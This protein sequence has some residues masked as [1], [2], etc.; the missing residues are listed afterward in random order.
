MKDLEKWLKNPAVAITTLIGLITAI[1]G[2]VAVFRSEPRLAMTITACVVA[3]AVLTTLAYVS[4][5][6]E[7]DLLGESH[8][9]FSRGTRI[10]AGVAG[11][12][13]IAAMV[14]FLVV[15]RSA[16]ATPRRT[17]VIAEF[18]SIP[19]TDSIQIRHR[20]YDE[21]LQRLKARRID[22]IA[23]AMDGQ[24]VHDET[25][26]LALAQRRHAT[27]VIWGWSDAEEA[28]I[29][30]FVRE[31][32]THTT[33]PDPEHVPWSLLPVSGSIGTR[34]TA[35]MQHAGFIA[36]FVIG[37][38]LYLD[39]RWSEGFA[40]LDEAAKLLPPSATLQN[41]ALLHFFRG[42][43]LHFAKPVTNLETLD[44]KY[45]ARVVCEYAEALR[46]DPKFA[47][48]WN[49]LGILQTRWTEVE[50]DNEEAL[51]NNEVDTSEAEACLDRAG[52]GLAMDPLKEAARLQPDNAA[53]EYNRLAGEW[54]FSTSMSDAVREQ[55]VDNL[56][57]LLMRDRSLFGA[58][59]I[60]G[61]IAFDDGDYTTA[62]RELGIVAREHPEVAGIHVNLAQAE[63]HL[64]H[65]AN[66]EREVAIE[67]QRNPRDPLALLARASLRF[68]ANDYAAAASSAE[69][70]LAVK[71]DPTWHE[72]A[73]YLLA[74][75]SAQTGDFARSIKFL[76]EIADAYTQYEPRPL[77]PH[78]L[79]G[80]IHEAAGETAAAALELQSECGAEDRA[81]NREALKMPRQKPAERAWRM[82]AAEC[83]QD[84]PRGS[85]LQDF[86]GRCL[87]RDPRAALKSVFFAIADSTNVGRYHREVPLHG[88]ACPLVFVPEGSA[89]R[90]A[91]AILVNQRG[92]DRD[93]IA[94]QP[95]PAS[96]A[97]TLR[98]SEVEPETSFIDLLQ[99]QYEYAGG[100]TETHTATLPE[101]ARS[102]QRYAILTMGQHLELTFPPPH[103][104]PLRTSI[105]AKGYYLP[106]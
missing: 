29:R 64:G 39:N 51:L 90:F 20:L 16:G 67:L 38:L 68:I 24:V 84:M 43:A 41:E 65:L 46:L 36:M 1:A 80:L 77:L 86:R 14:S 2:F 42:R 85:T 88:M 23:V 13:L 93:V 56:H 73:R 104:T 27:A 31:P 69:A 40:A 76:R 37:Q 81:E 7:T 103:A 83:T 79:L 6:R 60:L 5:A 78:L 89:W 34:G 32:A 10:S 48:A 87:P 58:R 91:T 100:R 35:V 74:G 33:L 21:L 75:A 70:A 25:E 97:G 18:D 57:H 3:A 11:A 72:A 61:I 49:N 106:H 101:L 19:N 4:L 62:R 98:I 94:R 66:A 54:V 52:I 55:F 26:A 22:G 47:A 45:Y 63:R 92:A 9:S 30:V 15:T 59:V 95:L 99:I 53:F 50:V 105:L 8:P 71:A 44:P 82:L 102:D 12:V 17:V 96:F 28:G